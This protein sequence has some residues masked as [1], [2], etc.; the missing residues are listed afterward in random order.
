MVPSNSMACIHQYDVRLQHRTWTSA[1]PLV[2]TWTT[3][4][5][6]DFSCNRTMDSDIALSDN[7]GLDV[8][9]VSNH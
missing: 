2:V 4:I 8:A 9:T 1:W 3:D 7:I 5:N 6:I